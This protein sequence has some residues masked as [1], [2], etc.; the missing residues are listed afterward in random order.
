M[1]VPTLQFHEK[2]NRQGRISADRV[3]K[4]EMRRARLL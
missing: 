2:F 1:A 4:L 3:R